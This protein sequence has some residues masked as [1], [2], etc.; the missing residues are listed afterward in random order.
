MTNM[1]LISES[2]GNNCNKVEDIWSDL[3]DKTGVFPNLNYM[4]GSD[5]KGANIYDN[6]Q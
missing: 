5:I 2:T 1:A 4:D 6:Y 3:S